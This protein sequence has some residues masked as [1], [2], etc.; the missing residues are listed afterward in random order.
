MINLVY[1]DE[2]RGKLEHVIA[3]RDDN[4]LGVFGALLYVTRNDGNLCTVSHALSRYT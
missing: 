4:E 2:T 3:Q 1:A